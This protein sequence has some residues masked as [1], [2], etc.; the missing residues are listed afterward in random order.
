MVRFETSLGDFTLELDADKAPITVANFLE[1]VDD[2]FF[3]GLVFHRVI[4]GFMIQGGGF[5]PDMKQKKTGAPIRNEAKNG[6]KNARGTIAMARTGVVD[7]A[8]A[9]FFINLVDNGFLD[10][11]GPA[12]FGYAVFGR[13]VEGMDTIDSIAKERTG[14]RA[15]H[16]DVPVNDVVI[17]SARRIGKD[18]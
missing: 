8:T 12:N 17:R 13:V 11:A 16:D 1:Y 4:P 14:R 5:T 10:H 2:G 7:S 15:G 6:L 9:Q 3:D 18:K